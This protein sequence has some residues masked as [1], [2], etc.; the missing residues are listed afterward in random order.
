MQQWLRERGKM[1]P[2]PDGQG[3]IMPM[4]SD[5]H[6]KLMPGMLT[7]DQ[8]KDLD[9]ARGTAFDRLFLTDMI[10]HHEG[11]ISMVKALFDSYGAAQDELVFKFASDVNVDQTTEVA[12]MRR[13]L[14][15]FSLGRTNP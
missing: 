4:G 11:A 13:M 3:M 1:V 8:M 10:Q 14:F 5:Q 12:R 7:P 2:E 6:P 15:V 9:A